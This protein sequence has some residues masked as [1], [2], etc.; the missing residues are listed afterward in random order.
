MIR[1][2]SN[3][4]LDNFLSQ[5]RFSQFLQSSSWNNFQRSLGNNVWQIGLFDDDQINCKLLGVA[6]IVE[7]KMPMGF[8]FLYCARGPILRDEI[9]EELK[10]KYLK[11]LLKSV[12]DISIKTKKYREIFFRF[13]PNFIFD[14]L[15]NIKKTKD[16]QPS[17]TLILDL[18]KSEEEI[19][20]SM[21]QKTRYN[22]RLAEKK[23]VKVEISENKEDIKYFL[24]L[25]NE[26]S[27]RDKFKAHSNE[28]YSKMLESR[29]GNSSLWFAKYNNKIVAANIVMSFGDT[30]TYTHGASSNEFRNIMAPHLLQWEQIKWAKKNAYEIYDFW[31]ISQSKKSAWAGFTRFK[32]GFNGNIENFSGTFDLI[33]S[34]VLYKIYKLYKKFI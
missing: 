24:D 5:Q 28:Y 14:N 9:S 21:H 11:V 1:E 10:N 13:E 33:Y 16:Y 15:E 12:R 19:L 3:Q 17:Q 4:E 20:F 34:D 18:K 27:T 30:V 23:G 25:I 7:K 8:S 32:N 29:A 6:S 2:I 22:I 26:T 31:G